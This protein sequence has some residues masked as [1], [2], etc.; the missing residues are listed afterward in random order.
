M[1]RYLPHLVHI[2]FDDVRQL[3]NFNWLVV[4]ERRALAEL[5]ES[6]ELVPRVGDV[7]ADRPAARRDLRA[8]PVSSSAFAGHGICPHR[9]ANRQ[10]LVCAIFA[11]VFWSDEAVLE[12]KYKAGKKTNRKAPVIRDWWDWCFRFW[13]KLEW[14]KAR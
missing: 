7:L 8:L 6:S 1:K 2:L 3:L 13:P 5:G 11:H 9:A 4:K 12:L 14:K 10:K